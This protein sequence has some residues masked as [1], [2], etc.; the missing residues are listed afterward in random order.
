MST[1]SVILATSVSLSYKD[2]VLLLWFYTIAWPHFVRLLVLTGT[3]AVDDGN[4]VLFFLVTEKRRLNTV[5]RSLDLKQRVFVA[6]FSVGN[7]SPKSAVTGIR[8]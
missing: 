3:W 1:V 7:R 5:A 4:K 8:S 6:L 2:S